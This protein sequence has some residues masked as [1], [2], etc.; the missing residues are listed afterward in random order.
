M[1]L[2]EIGTGRVS[3]TLSAE[4]AT[5]LA[6]DPGKQQR[7]GKGKKKQRKLQAALNADSNAEWEWGGC[8]DNV[9]YGVRKSREWMDAPFRKRSDIKTLVML[10]NNDAGRL[11][12]APHVLIILQLTMQYSCSIDE[13]SAFVFF[14]LQAVKNHMRLECKCHGLSGSCTLRTCWSKMPPFRDIGNR[15]KEHF[16]GAIKV[17]PSNDGRSFMAAG[18]SSIKPPEREDIVS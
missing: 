11:V 2:L 5:A 8:G 3:G 10:H 12:S 17:L 14:F 7:K 13:D 4:H 6:A 18:D 15:L 1:N 9:N 16:D